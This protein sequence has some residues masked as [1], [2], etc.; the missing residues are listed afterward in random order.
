MNKISVIVL[1][2]GLSKRFNGNK[3]LYLF[4][5]KPMIEYTFE[6]LKQ[7]DFDNVLV[8][9]RYSEVLELAKKHGFTGI[10]NNDET[11]DISNTIK[12]GIDKIKNTSIGAMLI[13][14]D[15]PY[16]KVESI[17]KL[18]NSFLKNSDNICALSIN[19]SPRNPAIFPKKYFNEL[20]ALNKN[21]KGKTIINKHLDDLILIE[22]NEKEL[23]DIDYKN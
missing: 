10:K 1:A 9:S 19:K 15:E 13:V 4:N 20:L 6:K 23:Q 7:I 21:E 3:L 16:L 2:S 18:V 17:I 11:F 14:A 5:G 8:V 22:T 12:L